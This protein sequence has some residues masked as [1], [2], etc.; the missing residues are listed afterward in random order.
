MG[1]TGPDKRTGAVLRRTGYSGAVSSGTIPFYV[2][3]LVVL[4][5]M[6]WSYPIRAAQSGSDTELHHFELSCHTCHSPGQSGSDNPDSTN[7]SGDINQLCSSGPCHNYDPV[8]NHPV[9]VTIDQSIAGDK[10]LDTAGR[11][12]CLTCHDM[13]SVSSTPG[14]PDEP[15]QRTLYTPQGSQFCASCHS[16]MDDGFWQGSHWQFSTNAHLSPIRP[17]QLPTSSGWRSGGIDAESHNCLSCHDE[18]SVTIPPENETRRQ[19]VARWSK[20]S[21]HP[22]G[23]DYS[24]IAIRKAPRYNYPL[25]N[26]DRIRFFDGRMGC[27]SC[28]SPYS[29]ER[30]FL[31]QS[32]RRSA[33]CFECHNL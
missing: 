16:K 9:G 10:P 22:I 13:P 27:G 21:D 25:M 4:G 29:N 8:M 6:I 19:Q 20:M 33:L 24:R 7:V 30:K 31:I 28:H 14:E 32:N 3:A 1:L 17:G 18:V 26:K 5:L 15:A 12:T 2:F 11:I 23:M